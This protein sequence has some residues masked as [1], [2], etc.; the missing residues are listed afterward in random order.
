MIKKFNCFL[1]TVWGTFMH[2]IKTGDTTIV[3]GH[4]YDQ[5]EIIRNCVLII[6]KCSYCGSQ[7]FAWQKEG[8][9]T[10]KKLIEI[11]GSKDGYCDCS[12]I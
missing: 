4:I 10:D 8:S 3:K 2:F 1:D 5:H 7:T 12:K 6:S 9:V 11:Y